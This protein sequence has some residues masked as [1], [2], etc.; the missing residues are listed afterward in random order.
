MPEIIF[1]ATICEILNVTFKMCGVHSFSKSFLGFCK[2]KCEGRPVMDAS[3]RRKTGVIYFFI[4][5]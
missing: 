1:F 4:F 2:Q 3:M 5:P